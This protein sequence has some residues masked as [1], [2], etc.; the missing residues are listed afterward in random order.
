MLCRSPV[1]TKFRAHRG[2]QVFAAGPVRRRL[3]DSARVPAFVAVG[4][5]KEQIAL[6]AGGTL[7]RI[8][9]PSAKWLNIAQHVPPE[10]LER[11][12]G[13]EVLESD[14]YR[15]ICS[16][17][18]TKVRSQFLKG[19]FRYAFPHIRRSFL[20]EAIASRRQGLPTTSLLVEADKDAELRRDTPQRRPSHRLLASRSLC[21]AARR[22]GGGA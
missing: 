12:G 16:G 4:H 3:G 17:R 19:N 2:Q 20:V 14:R 18:R 11:V 15:K 22:A 9:G 8:R 10:K 7:S 21:V 1:T 6:P 13:V 5:V